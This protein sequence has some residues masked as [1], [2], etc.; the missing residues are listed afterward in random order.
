M[1]L[2]F[3]SKELSKTE[4]VLRLTQQINSQF[5][6]SIKSNE[7][8]LKHKKNW[9]NSVSTGL[10]FNCVY[11]IEIQRPTTTKPGFQPRDKLISFL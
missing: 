4:F 5:Q 2:Y 3:F 8:G 9:G 11:I 6:L 7:Y 10:I 1:Y